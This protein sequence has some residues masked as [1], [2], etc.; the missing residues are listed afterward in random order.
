MKDRL[1]QCADPGCPVHEG[2]SICIRHAK[3]RLFRVDTFLDEGTLFCEQC[4]DDAMESGL[5]DPAQ[6]K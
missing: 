6:Q 3:Q 4:A 2:E 1:C 5:F